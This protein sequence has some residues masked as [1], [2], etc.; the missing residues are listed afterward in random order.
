M[1]GAQRI[2]NLGNR[3]QSDEPPARAL[4]PLHGPADSTGDV[5]ISSALPSDVSYRLASVLGLGRFPANARDE[6]MEMLAFEQWHRAAFSAATSEAGAVRVRALMHMQ[7]ECFCVPYRTT[8]VRTTPSDRSDSFPPSLSSIPVPQLYEGFHDAVLVAL[9]DAKW[10]AEEVKSQLQDPGA[11]A[12]A[13][14][15]SVRISDVP[16]DP[17]AKVTCMICIDETVLAKEAAQFTCGHYACMDC[18]THYV[19]E[20]LHQAPPDPAAQQ[21]GPPQHATLFEVPMWR[22]GPGARSLTAKWPP[23][24][25]APAAPPPPAAGGQGAAPAGASRRGSKA[26]LLPGQRPPVTAVNAGPASQC[27]GFLPGA[28]SATVAGVDVLPSRPLRQVVSALPQEESRLVCSRLLL[29]PRGTPFIRCRGCASLLLPPG[30]PGGPRQDVLCAE[31]CGVRTCSGREE[32]G[33]GRPHGARMPCAD[34][35][36]FEGLLAATRR[37]TGHLDRAA[38][39]ASDLVQA[40]LLQEEARA[41]GEHAEAARAA[42][43]RMH[44]IEAGLRRVRDLSDVAVEDLIGLEAEAGAEPYKARPEGAATPQ[45]EKLPCT[46]CF[47]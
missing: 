32:C 43:A 1:F 16:P 36:V 27:R 45:R 37:A 7:S 20:V 24:C 46:A 34:A 41:A 8:I 22:L 15:L 44:F 6:N 42:A 40:Q 3:A 25:C 31:N 5:N 35:Q 47:A 4:W 14:G 19:A 29:P 18:A 33:H 28:Y 30:R 21:G 9:D 38:G 23:R 10:N 11:F 13:H 17:D 26:P 12:A 39:D 2:I